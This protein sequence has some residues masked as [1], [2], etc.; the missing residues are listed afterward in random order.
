M[1]DG[2]ATLQD[3][4]NAL[5]RRRRSDLPVYEDALLPRGVLQHLGGGDGR[6]DVFGLRRLGTLFHAAFVIG[7]DP[8]HFLH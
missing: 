8:L 4:A 6:Q 2:I 3:E 7:L 5:W 1:R